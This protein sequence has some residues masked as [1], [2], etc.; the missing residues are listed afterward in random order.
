MTVENTLR[1]WSSLE[2]LTFN[3]IL[4]YCKYNMIDYITIET[5]TIDS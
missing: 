2:F 5:L 1:S 4:N 3:L